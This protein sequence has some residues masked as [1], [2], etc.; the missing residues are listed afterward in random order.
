MQQARDLTPDEVDQLQAM[1]TTSDND[2]ATALWRQV[3]GGK[4]IRAYLDSI[5]VH[6]IHPVDDDNW[7]DSTASAAGVAQLLAKLSTGQILDE[8]RRKLALQ[9]LSE[10]EPGQRWGVTVAFPGGLV[11]GTAAV[12]NGWYEATAGWRVNSVGMD[13]AH[14]GTPSLVMAVMTRNQDSMQTGVD[15]IEGVALRVGAAVH[16]WQILSTVAPPP[17]PA[18]STVVFAPSPDGVPRAAG[19]C[20]APSMVAHR[21]GAWRCTVDGQEFDP[22]FAIGSRPTDGILCDAHPLD[23]GSGLLIEL[24]K[25]LPTVLWPDHPATPWFLLLA[26]SSTCMHV[27]G[28]PVDGDGDRVTYACSDGSVIIGGVQRGTTW[29]AYKTTPDL[30]DALNTNVVTA[31]Y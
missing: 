19:D 13:E 7:G 2:S 22:C 16:G 5:G 29:S 25:P 18:T 14:A 3:G 28:P 6:G 8:A 31:W 21:T 9:L 15:T 23:A 4:A 26:D 24:T 12:K 20:P 27:T 1:I 10:V 11:P 30:A 17:A